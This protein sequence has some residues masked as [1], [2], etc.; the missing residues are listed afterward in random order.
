MTE[1][2]HV[3]RRRAADVHR[4]ASFDA[5]HEVDLRASRGVVE[6]QHP[7]RLIA[8]RSAD[9][10][11]FQPPESS[12][13]AQTAIPSDAPDRAEALA[14]LGPDRH[15]DAVAHRLAQR[16]QRGDEVR[17]HRLDVR[18]EPRRLRRDRDVDVLDPPAVL[19]DPCRRRRRAA[20]S[21]RRRGSCSSVA[22]NS[23]PRSGRPAGPSSASA[24]A[25]ATASPSEWPGE[26][27][28]VRRCVTP[29]STSGGASPNGC[30]S[31]PRPTRFRHAWAPSINACAS[32]RSSASVSLRLRGS[33]STTTTVP[34]AAST[35]AASSVPTAVARVRGFAARRAG[36]PAASAPTTRSSRA[37]GL[38]HPVVAHALHRVGDG[39]PG[40]RGVGAG[41]HRGDD[42]GEQR[43]DR[44]RPR[45]VVHDDD[46]GVVGNAREAGPHRCG[47]GRAAGGDA[48]TA[49]APS[50]RCSAGSTTTTPSHD[51]RATPTARSR[52]LTSPRRGE[53]L[54]RA[55]A[56]SASGG[57]DD[58]PGLHA[59][60]SGP[61]RPQQDGRRRRD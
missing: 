47:A 17:G 19:R 18:R 46:V 54:R 20:P 41:A 32:S 27:R 10:R 25:C 57:D 51:S 28:R 39:Q 37:H 11:W 3:V 1:V 60:Q 40:H 2:R 16:R 50:S 61:D 26:P 38:D 53:L 58:R 22:G 8:A 59:R 21:S 52:T 35:S 13:T 43:R 49:P 14:P 33:P 29:P 5:R 31:K 42:A 6:P 30:T 23:V 9:P 4:H 15:G 36:T 48:H 24:T 56:R 12:A 34:P 55:E 45:R 44:E 7:S